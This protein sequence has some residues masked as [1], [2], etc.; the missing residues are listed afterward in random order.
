MAFIAAGLPTAASAAELK[1]IGVSVMDMGNPFFTQ[2]AR[3]V[4]EAARRL[5]GPRVEVVANSCAYD[6][7]RQV[8]QLNRF[9]EDKVDLIVLTAVDSPLL[10]PVIARARAAGIAVV[11]VDVVATGADAT[12]MTDNVE[13]GRMACGY[14]AERLRGQG[15]LAII[16]GPRVSSV[17]DRV[18]GCLEVVRSHPGLTVLSMDRDAGGSTPGGFA[19][20]TELLSRHPRIDAVFAINDPTALGAEKAAEQAGREGFFIVSVDG[21]PPAVARLADPRSRLAATMGQRPALQA[22]RAVE[23]AL[24]LRQAQGR[25]GA[26]AGGASAAPTKPVLIAPFPV[27]RTTTEWPEGAW[28]E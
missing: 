11:G 9:I 12:V 1:R 17:S 24:R 13:A 18:N 3:G 27:D 22:Q 19:V 14:I 8:A 25:G 5:A 6:A 26:P 2:I 10:Q 7:P 16:N 28:R 23:I 21:S 15:L 4:E 20:M